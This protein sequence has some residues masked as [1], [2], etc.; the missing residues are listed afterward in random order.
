MTKENQKKL[1]KLPEPRKKGALSLEEC[2][3]KRRSKRSFDSKELT[4]EEI[5]QLLWSL[6]GITDKTRGFRAAPSAGAL[7]PLEIYAVKSEGFYHYT[8]HDHTLKRLSKKDLR[9]PLTKAALGQ[10]YIA[11]APFTIVICA[12]YER[13]CSRYGERGVMYTHIE[14]G[15]AAQN[16]L[17]QAVA[18]NL[19]SVP[20]G[21]FREA[22]VTKALSLPEAHKPV[23][24]LPV[25]QPLN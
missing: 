5:S 11:Q 9:E 12:V 14:T 8:P 10:R 7:Y 4:R 18:L 13:I 19:G 3:Q 15:H 22:E 1:E 25:G 20:I 24:I 21:A 17:L 23:Y 16:L 6:Q 2:I